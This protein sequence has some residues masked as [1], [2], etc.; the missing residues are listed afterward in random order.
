MHDSFLDDARAGLMLP[1]LLVFAPEVKARLSTDRS[2]H[3]L[4]GSNCV[5]RPVGLAGVTKRYVRKAGLAS[6]AD[7]FQETAAQGKIYTTSSH[8]DLESIPRT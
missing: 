1:Q 8:V 5:V 2:L 7:L 4:G 6:L 3:F